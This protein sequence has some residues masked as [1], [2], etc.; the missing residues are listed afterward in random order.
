MI[1]KCALVDDEPLALTLIESYINKTPFLELCGKYNS[2]VAV[3]EDIKGK[4][5]DLLFLDIQMPTLNGLELSEMLPRNLRI[6]FTTAFDQYAIDGFKANALD[7]LL[8]PICYNEFLK[9]AHKALEWFE[10]KYRTNTTDENDFIYVKSDY[11]LIQVK[12][13]NILYIEGLKDYLKIYL[14]GE[15]HPILTLNSMKSMEEHLPSPRFMRVHR[16][17]IVQMNKIKTLDKGQIVFSKTRI[18]ISDSYKLEITAYLNK[19]IL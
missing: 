10:M 18:T 13:D 15:T 8:K 14:E 6:V 4:D 1:L 19:Y 3:V 16:S 9:A 2:A 5:I 7:Y 12:L 17:Y 11:K